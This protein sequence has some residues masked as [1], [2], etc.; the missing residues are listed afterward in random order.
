MTWKP[1]WWTLVARAIA[2]GIF[3]SGNPAPTQR[4]SRPEFGTLFGISVAMP[5]ATTTIHTLVTFIQ[6]GLI[7]KGRVGA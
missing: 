7:H 4:S 5:I 3:F 1:M 2:A 6:A